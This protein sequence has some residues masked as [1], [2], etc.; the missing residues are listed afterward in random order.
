[1]RFTPRKEY[2]NRGN[3]IYNTKGLKS[4]AL[5]FEQYLR[6]EDFYFVL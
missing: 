4:F 5:S 3:G 1:M 2:L 6:K